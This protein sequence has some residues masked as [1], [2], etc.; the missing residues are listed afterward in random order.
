MKSRIFS[1]NELK[2]IGF[3]NISITPYPNSKNQKI[4]KVSFYEDYDAPSYKFK[5][6]KELYVRVENSKTKIIIEE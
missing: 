4:F 6:Q 1:K 5:G 2:R 3:S